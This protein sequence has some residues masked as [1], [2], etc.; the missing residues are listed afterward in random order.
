[1][2]EQGPD[3]QPHSGLDAMDAARRLSRIDGILNWGPYPNPAGVNGKGVLVG[4]VDEVVHLLLERELDVAA[5][6]QAAGP[7]HPGTITR[8]TDERGDAGDQRDHPLPAPGQHV[9]LGNRPFE[10]G[11]YQA[12]LTR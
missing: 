11:Q 3:A 6:G 8:Q 2:E 1:M 12:G 10:G 4:L 5:D 9:T 7:D